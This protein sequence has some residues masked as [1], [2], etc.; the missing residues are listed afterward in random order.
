MIK[1]DWVR[2]ILQ[3]SHLELGT[4]PYIDA[5]TDVGSENKRAC[6][7]L[8]RGLS[9]PGMSVMQEVVVCLFLRP[10][11]ASNMA[12]PAKPGLSVIDDKMENNLISRMNGTN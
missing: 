3:H 2:Q 7:S 5:I 12:L 1:R 8:R 11:K 10:N 6:P 4:L 9:A